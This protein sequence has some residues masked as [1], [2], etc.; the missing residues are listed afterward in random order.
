M[1]P[2]WRPSSQVYQDLVAACLRPDARVLDLGCG[3]GGV[4]ERLRPQAGFVAGL[5][6]DESS[7]REHRA[8][9]LGLSCGLAQALPYVD[10][11]FDLVCSSWVLEHLAEPERVFAEVNRALR[12]GGHFIFLTPN[13]RHPLLVLNRALGWTQGRLVDCAYGRAEENIFPALYRANT[14]RQIEQL[15]R[16]AGME[17]VS[18]RFVEDPT[19]LAFSQPLFRLACLLARVIPRWMWVHM[20]GEYVT[21]LL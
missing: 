10:D 4:M 3:R 7:L 20:V 12:P 1:R 5:D 17:Q 6:P 19:Y 14:A 8:P 16:M 9:L 21:P 2:G 18:L 15:A 11:I 13:V